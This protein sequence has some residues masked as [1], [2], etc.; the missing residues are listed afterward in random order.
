[1]CEEGGDNPEKTKTVQR[2]AFRDCQ[3]SGMELIGSTL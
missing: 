2:A 3:A 1:M